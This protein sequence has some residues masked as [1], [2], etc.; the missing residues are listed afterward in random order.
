[1]HDRVSTDT[2][3]HSHTHALN[4]YAA[5]PTAAKLKSDPRFTGSGVRIAFLDSGFYPHPDISNRIIAFHDIHGEEKTLH[6]VIEPKAHHWHGTQTVVSCAGSGQLSDGVYKGIASDAELVLVKVSRSGKISDDSIVTG[7]E[8]IKKNRLEYEIRILN[9]SLGGDTNAATKD[10]RINQL[11]E[12]LVEAGVV[13]TVAAGNSSESCTIPPAS[14][15]SVMTV[16]GYSDGN[17]LDGE[18]LVLYHSS[19]GTT[20]DGN[21][22]P[23]LIAP[24]MF[25][26]API[27]PNT[28]DYREA[29]ILSML[30]SSPDFSFIALLDEFWEEAGFDNHI[31]NLEIP[32]AR[33]F[34]ETELQ[35]RKIIATHYQHVDGTSFAAPITASVIAQ[36]LEA[37]P[38]LG[39]NAIKHIL[40][41]TAERITSNRAI[42]QGYGVLNARRA[43]ELAA[44]ERH[45]GDN[46]GF[47]APVRIGEMVEF[48]FHDDHAASV[49][50][51]G[52]FNEWNRSSV[53]LK[54]TSNGI[55]TTSI[56]IRLGQ[57]VRYKL[58]IDN[59]RWIEDPTHGMKEEDGFGGFHSVLEI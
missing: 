40:I 43:V 26:A 55:W 18:D 16:G 54:R 8:W 30:S 56:Q 34:V 37:N 48:T 7:L 58:L 31:L 44:S 3:N 32:E 25:V 42:R 35:K 47:K 45:T 28:P 59:E 2:D 52:D 10:S 50:L 41:T 15:P 29:E 46:K 6:S 24:A 1:M 14:S 23:E 27:L 38:L 20:V 53:P 17:V 19:F 22:K 57:R 51:V 21:V 4:R 39:P 5:V 13:I 12:E 49:N 36:M 33:Q 9:I 11:C